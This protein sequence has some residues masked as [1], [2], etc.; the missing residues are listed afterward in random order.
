M[1]LEK[2]KIVIRHYNEQDEREWLDIHAMVMVDFYAWWVA[3][4]KKP[5]Y[6]NEIIDLV[7]QYESKIVGF[8]TVEINSK[9]IPIRIQVLSGN[10]VSIEIIAALVLV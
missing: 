4:H 7:A 6:E 10:S 2:D 9:V 1:K 8:I 5:Y 3:I